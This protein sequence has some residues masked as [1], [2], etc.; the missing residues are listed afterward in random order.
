VALPKVGIP[1]NI[2]LLPDAAQVKVRGLTRGENAKVSQLIED[3]LIKDAEVF[4]LAAATDTSEADAADWYDNTPSAV[5]E[6][7][8]NEIGALTR[9]D[10]G[11]TK[12]GQADVHGR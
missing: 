1:T 11:A 6:M 4:I 9:L 10:E 5:V 3:K 12:S 7:V 8:L 2:V